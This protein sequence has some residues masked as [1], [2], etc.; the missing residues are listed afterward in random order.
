MHAPVSRTHQAKVAQ[1]VEPGAAP[2]EKIH[3]ILF[4]SRNAFLILN[5]VTK[6]AY[7]AQVGSRIS[8]IR[9]RDS[10]SQ[11]SSRVLHLSYPPDR[12]CCRHQ[13]GR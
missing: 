4:Y 2:L 12:N 10:L 6:M 3:I 13:Y 9:R 7:G 1:N 8:S 5:C 11:I